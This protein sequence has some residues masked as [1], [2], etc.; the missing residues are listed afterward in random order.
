MKQLSHLAGTIL[1][2]GSLIFVGIYLENNWPSDLKFS[3]SLAL[4]SAALYASTHI[5]TSLAW[6]WVLKLKGH[7]IPIRKGFEICLISQAA[8]YIPGNIAHHIGRA[9]LAKG[10]GVSLT[11]STFIL[12]IEI[13]CVC[14]AALLVGG[15]LISYWISAGCLIALVLL[16]FTRYRGLI[17]PIL[18]FLVGLFVAGVSFAVLLQE[19]MAVP[20][21]PIAWLAGFLLP[22]AP[23]GLGVREATI[24]VLLDQLASPATL[25]SAVV[26]HRLVTA[27]VDI[28][29]AAIAYFAAFASIQSR[30]PK[31]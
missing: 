27:V 26:A 29:V 3:A 15:F 24:L 10:E 9:T 8:K 18:F 2:L 16:I 25:A 21:Y 23:A 22:G 6:H 19:S 5:T 17:P 4:A 28:L 1:F 12:A 31:S 7:N 20:V 14:F 13:G 11:D 30:A